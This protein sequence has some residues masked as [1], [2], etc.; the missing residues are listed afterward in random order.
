LGSF[1]SQGGK[2]KL[3]LR[4]VFP[5]AEVLDHVIN[6]YGAVEGGHQTLERLAEHLAKS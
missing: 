5:T 1:D 6:V 4:M 3:T 2:T